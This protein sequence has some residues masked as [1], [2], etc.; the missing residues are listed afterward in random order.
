MT[1]TCPICNL[2]VP[3]AGWPLDNILNVGGEGL[4]AAEICVEF[5]FYLLG[6]SIWVCTVRH[7]IEMR[8]KIRSILLFRALVR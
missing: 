2:C 8:E 6:M 1:S 7:N 5:I 4:K 3:C